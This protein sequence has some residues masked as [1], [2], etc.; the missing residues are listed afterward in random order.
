MTTDELSQQAINQALLGNWQKAIAL[1]Q[2]ILAQN[3]AEIEA[4]SRLAKAF[5]ESGQKKQALKSY[6]RVLKLDRFNPI[7]KSAL[8]KL[9]AKKI[10]AKKNRVQA[11]NPKLFLEESGKTKEVHL[12]ELADNKTLLG[13]DIG[14]EIKLIP[15]KRAIS[16]YTNDKTYLGKIP[17]DLSLRLIKLIKSGNQYQAVVKSIE[18]KNLSLFIRETKQSKKN[19]QTPSFPFAKNQYHASA[20][21]NIIQ[22][23]PIEEMENPPD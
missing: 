22:R 19:S 20:P 6:R 5:L 16:V 21:L 1:N 18:P 15:R 8:K 12:T 11:I 3:P 13:V 10:K 2:Q 23:E 7:A 17:D 4:L 14:E 9:N